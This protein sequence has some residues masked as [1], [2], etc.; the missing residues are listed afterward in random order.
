MMTAAERA[1]T[2]PVFRMLVHAFYDMFASHCG[3]GAGLTPSE[4]REAS[5]YAWQ[6]YVERHSQPIPILVDPDK[7]SQ[8]DALKV[9]PKLS[10]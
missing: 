3:T 8:W 5:G 7:I 9:E 4:V 10:Q 1:E 6:M 2:D